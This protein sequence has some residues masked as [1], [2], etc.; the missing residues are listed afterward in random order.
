MK[1]VL[2]VSL[3]LALLVSSIVAAERVY[4]SWTAGSNTST[5]PLIFSEKRL[6]LELWSTYKKNILEPGS[7]RTLDREQNGITTSE[8]QSNT[9]LRAAWMDDKIVFDTSWE[10]TKNNLQRDDKLISS[11][12]GKLPNGDYGIQKD[13]GGDK[14]TSAAD[15]DIALALLMAY[16]RWNDSDYLYDAKPLIE[17]IWEN[18]VV[19]SNGRPIL[20]ANNL[21]QF[22]Q[23]DVLVNPSYLAPYAYKIFAKVDPTHDWSGLADNSYTVLKNVSVDNLDTQSSV[24]LPPN[25]IR[26]DKITGEFT[27]AP[28]TDLTTNYGYDAARVPFRMALD[29]EWNRDQRAREV[30][31]G[32]SFLSHEWNKSGS[33]N[34]VYTHDG[35]AVTTDQTPAM[36]GASLGY[37]EVIEP[38]LAKQVYETQLLTLYSP[39]VQSWKEPLGYYDDNWA[40]FGIALHNGYLINLTE[41]E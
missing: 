8:A 15:T 41:Q 35:K 14:T 32:Y 20:V 13:S 29:W 1:K 2:L 23:D 33:L 19:Q 40:W 5:T 10:W 26:M 11:R 21:E 38:Q 6:N 27:A 36:Y 17:S 7:L 12:F 24:G 31:N 39:D 28:D 37:F 25:W 16:T 9:M 22:S 4:S 3:L 30:L 18:E 34:A